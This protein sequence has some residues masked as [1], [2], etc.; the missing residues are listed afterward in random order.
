MRPL[1]ALVLA[2]AL[3]ACSVSGRAT[4]L[5][6]DRLYFPT[7]VVHV[8]SAASPDGVLYVASANFDKRWETGWVTAI[9][10]S[11]VGLP[12]F[13]QPVNPQT[14]PPQLALG[15]VGAR[16][17]AAVSSFT[18]QM[19]SLDL[20][21]GAVRLFVPSR[22]E[23]MKI[24]ALDAPALA[25]GGTPELRCFTPDGTSAQECA[26]S[27]PSLT[28]REFE[29]SATGVPRAPAPFGV[30]VKPLTC[31][32]ASQC[33]VSPT[34]S[35]GGCTCEAGRCKGA[36]KRGDTVGGQEPLADVY[37]THL[38]DADSPASSFRDFRGY[39]VRLASNDPKVTAESFIDIGTGPTHGVA[40]G[41]RWVYASGRVSAEQGFGTDLLRLVEPAGGVF[42]TGLERAFRVAS[43]RGLAL[44]SDEGR[45]YV[46]T[47][48]PDSLLIASIE[49]PDSPLPEIR[50]ERAVAVPGGADEVVSI[51][52]PG[53]SDLVAVT[54]TNAG[55]L[56]FYDDDVGDLVA[57]VP[58]VGLQPFG[59][60]VD[61]RGA[62]ARLYVTNFG[63][64]RVAVVDVPDLARPQ[65]AR[66]VAHLGPQQLCLTRSTSSADTCDGGTP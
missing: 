11:K 45:V 47:R 53:R 36:A 3:P 54:C 4:E 57:Q 21:N 16:G 50:A 7:G 38:Q 62:G 55:A 31:L 28:P 66:L 60:A 26:T 5:P 25:D 20:G 15:G 27:A 1:A 64:G 44:A 8:D 34:C 23:G 42:T 9:D 59:I 29:R 30:A 41:R 13:G 2:A 43:A 49:N 39:L 58:G 32:V 12:P 63:D 46:A 37:V 24:Q 48:S 19:T 33:A 40:A 52:R 61:R 51:P 18:G 56:V 22:S 10:L 65:D 35:D 6:A 17:V 14:G